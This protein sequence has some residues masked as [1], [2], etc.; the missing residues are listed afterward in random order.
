MLL[1]DL[2]LKLEEQT[3]KARAQIKDEASPKVRQ[4]LRQWRRTIKGLQRKVDNWEGESLNLIDDIKDW[5]EYR[6]MKRLLALP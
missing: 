5:L 6:E 4:S 3:N 1:S 2:Y